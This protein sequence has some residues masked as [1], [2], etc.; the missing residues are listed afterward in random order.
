VISHS[1]LW[2]A[3]KSEEEVKMANFGVFLLFTLVSFFM[4]SNVQVGSRNLLIETEDTPD[5]DYG[6]WNRA[7]NS[8]KLPPPTTDPNVC[9]NG[10]K[11]DGDKWQEQCSNKYLKKILQKMHQKCTEMH[12]NAQKC[13]E[14]HRNAQ[15]CTEMDRNAQ[16]CTEIHRN[17]PNSCKSCVVHC[18]CKGENGRCDFVCD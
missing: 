3:K 18:E 14:R 5:G 4:Q 2:T 6:G 16:K 12:R 9:K 17:A 13:T 11:S 1:C 7:K 15:K 8:E 10:K